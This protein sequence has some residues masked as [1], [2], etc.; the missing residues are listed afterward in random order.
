MSTSRTMN[1]VSYLIPD[2]GDTYLWGTDLSGFLAGT[3]SGTL[4]KTGGLFALTAE[5]D[6][7]PTYGLK[8]SYF[9]S[10]TSNTASA[11]ALRLA[12]TDTIKWRNAANSADMTLS[13]ATDTLTYSGAANIAGNTTIGGTLAVTGI[14][15]APSFI[16]WD[17]TVPGVGMYSPAANTL[18]FSTATTERVRIDSSGNVGIGTSS[19]IWP[20]EMY[21]ASGVSLGLFRTGLSTAYSSLRL[22][23]DQN[24]SVRSLEVAYTGSAYSG[25]YVPSGPSGE[26]AVINSTGAYPL[27]LATNNTARMLVDAS[28]NVGI[29]TN[30]P[31][32][33]GGQ[34]VVN[35]TSTGAG[36]TVNGVSASPMLYLRSTTNIA[37]LRYGSQ[38]LYISDN[39]DV[40]KMRINGVF[41]MF[42]NT[43]QSINPVNGVSFYDTQTSTQVGIGHASGTV[44]GTTFLNFNY[45]G[46]SIG[47]VTQNGTTAVA[48]NTSSD[49]RLKKNIVNAPEASNAIDAIRV[50]S[51]DWKADNSHVTWG[52][53]AQELVNVAPH[54][55]TQ[56]GDEIPWGVDYSKL[57]PM[58]VKEVQSLRTRIAALE[59][60]ED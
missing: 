33:I 12:N 29:N 37:N 5:T 1:G 44:S 32:S 17:P 25:T 58:L 10:R 45:N 48:F 26:Q 22:Y 43:T 20:L 13:L 56:G 34:L 7:G 19:T 9:K 16:P 52:V 59:A 47:S 55:V 8:S 51:H 50:V 36:I 15:T 3:S 24:S 41:V 39:A 14:I 23:N 6:F 46:A 53:I 28:G 31:A 57:V 60:L 4:Q 18:G 21:N 38:G 49:E 2:Q 40:E 30:N 42:G 27:V 54:A 11:G 35:Q